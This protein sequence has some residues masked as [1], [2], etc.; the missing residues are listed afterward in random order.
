[1]KDAKN[2]KYMTP[3]GKILS[4]QILGLIRKLPLQKTCERNKYSEN[5]ALREI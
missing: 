3:D 2:D 5:F 1:M 4:Q